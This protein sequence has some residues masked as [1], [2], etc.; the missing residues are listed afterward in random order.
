MR[1]IRD[2]PNYTRFSMLHETATQ[3]SRRRE[4]YHRHQIT[5]FIPYSAICDHREFSSVEQMIHTLTVTLVPIVSLHR[6]HERNWPLLHGTA[7]CTPTGPRDTEEADGSR[8]APRTALVS[9][10]RNA[11]HIPTTARNV[12][13]SQI[14]AQVFRCVK[15]E[16]RTT[17]IA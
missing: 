5:Y 9:V 15:A 3:S 16:E 11:A 12:N 4:L 13:G 2:L 6:T 14:A 8:S 7:S 10:Q 1:I 17:E